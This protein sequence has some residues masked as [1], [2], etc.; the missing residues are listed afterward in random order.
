MKGMPRSLL[1][2]LNVSFSQRQ[3]DARLS[4]NLSFKMGKRSLP[5]KLIIETNSLK[6]GR[7]KFRFN[8]DGSDYKPLLMAGSPGDY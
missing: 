2:D 6:S 8:P 3:P 4:R 7:I 5:N 1:W